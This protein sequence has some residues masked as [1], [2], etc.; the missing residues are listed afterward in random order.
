[1]K[2]QLNTVIIIMLLALLQAC[3]GSD[4]PTSKAKSF[5]K[6]DTN[7]PDGA[8]M[9]MIQSF[10]NNDVKALMQASMSEEDYKK[11]LAGFEAQKSTPSESDKAQFAQTMGMLTSDGAVEKLMAMAAPQLEQ[12]RTQLPMLLMM[13]KG[14]VGPSIQ[15]NPDIPDDQKES[16]TKIANAFID[17]AS[18]TDLLSEEVTRKAITAA[19]ETAKSLDMNSLDDLQNMSFDQAMGKA[20]MVMGGMKNVMSVYGISIDDM[21]D[22]VNVSDVEENGDS[23]NMKIAYDFF[24]ESFNQDV[25]MKKVNGQWVADQ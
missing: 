24:G 9:S 5:A 19:V 15:S 8:L 7:S 14:M 17:Y 12:A 4:D 23:A 1:M 20:S 18:E 21:L 10:K 11:A 22:S 2:K 25:K 3:G 6:V 16:L 13:G